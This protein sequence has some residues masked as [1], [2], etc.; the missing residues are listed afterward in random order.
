MSAPAP[1][2]IRH[3]LGL[4]AGSVRALLGLSVLAQ[5]WILAVA[6]KDYL[7]PIF[8]YLLFLKV[9]ILVHY[10]AAHGKTVGPVVSKRHALGLPRG[11]IRIVLMGGMI[12]LLFYVWHVH[13][14]VDWKDVSSEKLFQLLGLVLAG[15]FIGHVLTAIFRVPGGFIPAWL[16]DVQA[17]LAL[18]AAVGLAV[19]V[20]IYSVI[21]TSVSDENRVLATNLE[22]GL[23]A[24]VGFYFGA[25]S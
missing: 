21:N 3:A 7:P 24:L 22:L 20:L 14:E 19:V 13:K 17:W 6:S 25:R 5:L 18:L 8:M 15:F 4:P 2:P 23:A 12:G 9:L 10:Y 16:Q 11:S 1:A